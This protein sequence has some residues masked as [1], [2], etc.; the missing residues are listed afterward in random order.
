MIFK[1][2][3]LSLRVAETQTGQSKKSNRFILYMASV[4]FASKMCGALVSL[5]RPGGA[6]SPGRAVLFRRETAS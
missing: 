3:R 6:S 5:V 2:D 4:H 1:Y